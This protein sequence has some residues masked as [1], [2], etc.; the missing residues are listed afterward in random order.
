MI[1]SP[2]SAE[3]AFRWANLLMFWDRNPRRAKRLL[4]RALELQPQLAQAQQALMVIESQLDDDTSSS[5][6]ETHDDFMLEGIQ[7]M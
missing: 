4:E 3:V 2:E 6:L 7:G 1:A 5:G